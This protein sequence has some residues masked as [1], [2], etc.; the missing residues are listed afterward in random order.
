[1]NTWLEFTPLAR[2]TNATLA[3]GSNVNRTIRRFS[4]TVTLHL[5][6]GQALLYFQGFSGI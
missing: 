4:A 5:N 1:L 2:A 3:P 6:P